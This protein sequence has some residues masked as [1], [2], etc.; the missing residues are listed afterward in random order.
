MLD[1][2]DIL[3]DSDVAGQTFSVIR[4]TNTVD[5]ATGLNSVTSVTLGP[6]IGA[7]TP[8]DA[9]V[10]RE[11]ASAMI[12]RS[13]LVTA[14][15]AFRASSEGVLPD[16]IDYDGVQYT[17]ESL[18]SWR[19]VAGFMKVKAISGHASDPDIT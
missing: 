4:R 1:F 16:V 10:K 7:V 2:S 19:R 14:A 8:E 17:V 11:D 6:F 3:A 13:I 5:P 18:K 15:F 12:P 9:E